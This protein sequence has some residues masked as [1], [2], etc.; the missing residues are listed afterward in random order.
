MRWLRLSAGVLLL[1]GCSD[2]AVGPGTLPPLDPLG[3][4]LGSRYQDAFSLQVSRPAIFLN[5]A[6]TLCPSV[7][8]LTTVAYLPR[9]SASERRMYVMHTTRDGRSLVSGL[10]GA[11]HYA[12]TVKL[13]PAGAFKVLTVI[14]TWSETFRASDVALLRQAQDVIN[15]QHADFARR[16][17]YDSPI[18]RFE[19]TNVTRSGST[20]PEPQSRDAMIAVAEL[21]GFDARSFDFLVVINLDPNAF[22][23]GFALV[24]PTAPSFVYLG[25]YLGLQARPTTITMYDLAGAAYHHEIGHHWGWRHDWTPTCGGVSSFSPFITA[26]VLFGWEDTDGDGV[27]EILDP[28]PYGR[29]P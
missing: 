6:P 11:T 14:L 26:P 5:D 17:R 8:Y 3:A 22:E 23:G 1:A 24:G 15:N 20:V 18:V 29:L 13:V 12:E 2:D 9:V 10:D 27:P 21:A 25:N 28:A 7:G 16:K 4:A 19:F